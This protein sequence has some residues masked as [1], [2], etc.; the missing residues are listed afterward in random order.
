V[1]LLELLV[2]CASL[3]VN[4]LPSAGAI[5]EA[6][7]LADAVGL[8]MADWWEPTAEGYLNHVPKARIV[9]A[10]NEAGP[11]LADD[12]VRDMKKDVL[13]AK[14]ASRLAGKRWLPPQ[15]RRVAG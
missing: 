11:G 12:G 8:D 4:V 10:L 15:L 14:A 9:E 2:L 6:N 13:V 5:A 3:T 1:D 7:A